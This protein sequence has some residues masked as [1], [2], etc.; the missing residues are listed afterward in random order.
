MNTNKLCPICGSELID[1]ARADGA[2]TNPKCN[3]VEQYY[4]DTNG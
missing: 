3:Y 2:C 1:C 4:P